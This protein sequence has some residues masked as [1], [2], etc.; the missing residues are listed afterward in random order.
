MQFINIPVVIL[1]ALGVLPKSI[2]S[3]PCLNSETFR[4]E[5]YGIEDGFTAPRSCHWIRFKEDRRQLQCQDPD[6]MQN[7]PQVCGTCCDDD[8][9]YVFVN[10]NDVRVSCSYIAKNPKRI[11]PRRRAYCERPEIFE[12]DVNIRDACPHSCD[13]CLSLITMMPTVSPAPSEREPSK[14]PTKTPTETPTMSPTKN[15]TKNPTDFPT[16]NPTQ[17]PTDFPTK[18]P[19]KRPT[20]NPTA[21]P[22]VYLNPSS[23]PSIYPSVFCEDDPDFEFI[24][25]YNKFPVKCEWLTLSN[26][27][28]RQATYCPRAAIKS[29]CK[30]TC[31]FCTCKDDWDY[32]FEKMNTNK[33]RN[34]QWIARNKENFLLRRARYCYKNNDR[35]IG[36][37]IA[38]SCTMSC[39]FCE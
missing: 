3:A 7:C 29:A 38:D 24:M 28:K 16:K 13:M 9:G 17:N 21:T 25:N 8:P 10:N 22:T 27:N 33:N 14:P 37:E 1:I 34:C 12:N 6:V 5:I 35:S 19:S 39:G 11:I 26:K 4:K 36:S 32:R 15:P 20:Q 30:A 31:N 23:E 2:H 18:S